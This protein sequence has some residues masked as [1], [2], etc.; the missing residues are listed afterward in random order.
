ME[1]GARGVPGG[2]VGG[3]GGVDGLLHDAQLGGGLDEAELGEGG[4]CVLDSAEGSELGEGVLVAVKE[5]VE[6]GGLRERSGEVLFEGFERS[7]FSEAGAGGGFRIRGAE[8]GAVVD[9]AAGIAF[10]EEEDFL[11]VVFAGGA[12]QEGGT[13][14]LEAGEVVEVGFLEVAVAVVEFGGGSEGPEDDD[15]IGEIGAEFG[16][17]LGEF[18]DREGLGEAR[19]DEGEQIN[20]PHSQYHPRIVE[21]SQRGKY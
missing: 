2:E 10:G 11:R 5:G 15:A 4:L 14:L 3:D 9:F 12:E 8:D 21:W 13:G 20:R 19:E 17:A 7:N 16:A 1:A 18:R 6:I